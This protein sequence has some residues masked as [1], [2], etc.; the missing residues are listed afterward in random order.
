M[1]HVSLF[2]FRKQNGILCFVQK[3]T[4]FNLPAVP[5][6][7]TPGCGSVKGDKT[8]DREYFSVK[9]FVQSTLN[10]CLLYLFNMLNFLYEICQNL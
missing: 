5:L 6:K 10:V 3:L 2:G 1:G 7:H 9:L 8:F 4:C